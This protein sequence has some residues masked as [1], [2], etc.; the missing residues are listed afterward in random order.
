LILRFGILSW[1]GR[2]QIVGIDV[3]ANGIQADQRPSGIFDILEF[4]SALLDK[5]AF[6]IASFGFDVDLGIITHNAFNSF[7]YQIESVN[8]VKFV[9]E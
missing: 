5:K 4:V 9:N 7:C 6:V 3:I 8:G 1:L 2:L